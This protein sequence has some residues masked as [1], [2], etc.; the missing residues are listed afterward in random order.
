MRNIKK[1]KVN[2]EKQDRLLR[3]IDSKVEGFDGI[4]DNYW[5]EE[6]VVSGDLGIGKKGNAVTIF[7]E[8]EIT[9]ETLEINNVKSAFLVMEDTRKNSK[10]WVAMAVGGVK[11]IS[12][13]LGFLSDMTLESL[14]KMT[15]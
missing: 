1:N 6:M 11:K 7:I 9:G 15:D 5:S 13:V 3:V 10:G 14:R 4:S 8:D 2:R 12:S